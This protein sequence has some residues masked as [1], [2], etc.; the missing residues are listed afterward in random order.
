MA[1]TMTTTKTT[2]LFDGLC[3]LCRQSVKWI[4]RLDWLHAIDYQDAQD[5]ETVHSRYPS[6]DHDAI[7]GQIH[8]VAPDGK[9]FVG[10]EGMRRI[11][12]NLPLT[13][14]LYPFMF[15]PGITWA[16]PRVYGWIANHRY[17]INRLIGDPVVC[18][19]GVCKIHGA[20][21]KK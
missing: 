1:A 15:I 19:D 4:R 2:V 3:A 16:E 9:V 12:K 21:T 7:Y 18:E 5:W 20:A 6:L 13:M 10:Y 8:V 17:Q 11:M 14:W